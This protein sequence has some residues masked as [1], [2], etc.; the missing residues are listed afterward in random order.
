MDKNAG[1]HGIAILRRAPALLVA[2]AVGAVLFACMGGAAAAKG[3]LGKDGRIHA[4]YRVKG[5]PKGSLRVVPARKRCR[6]GE[7]KVAWSAAGRNGQAGTAGG[8]GQAGAN[9]APSSNEVALKTQISSLELKVDRLEK[10]LEGILP[11]LEGTLAALDGL[12]NGSLR[13]AVDVANALTSED[14]TEALNDLPV[15][16]SLCTGT[17]AAT[18]G[19]NDLRTGITGLT[20]LGLPGLSLGGL[21]SL[22]ETD[23]FSCVAP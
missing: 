13:G 23:P 6:R 3:P 14:P 10:A 21:G 5:K 22:P 11:D 7:R 16:K 1:F 12:D 20:V 8:G 9:A 2:L 17:T 4:C 15:V 18:Q 19:V